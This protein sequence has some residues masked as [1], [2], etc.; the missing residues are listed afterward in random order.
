VR[1]EVGIR[2]SRSVDN[3][4]HHPVERRSESHEIDNE[5]AG[6]PAAVGWV[7]DNLSIVK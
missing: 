5:K 7:R 1:I 3:A 4:E 2:M 6:K